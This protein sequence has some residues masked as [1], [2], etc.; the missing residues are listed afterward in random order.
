MRKF[1]L[2]IAATLM[3][4]ASA[5]SQTANSVI[6]PGKGNIDVEQLNKKIDL[7]MDISRLSVSELRVLRN[8]F[9]AR[10]GYCFMNADLRGIFSATSWYDDIM[11]KRFD[12]EGTE[13]AMKP[14]TYTPAEQAFI[15][16]LKAREDELLKL[17]FKAS[18]ANVV[19]M[20]NIVNPFQMSE[21][22][23][24]LRTMLGRQGFAIVPSEEQQLFHIYE[25]NDYH[26][27]PNFVTTDL[28]LQVYHMYFDTALKQVERSLFIPML[29]EYT[30]NLY[31]AMTQRVQ[32]AKIPAMKEAAEWDAA[33]FAIAYSLLTDKPLPPVADRLQKMVQDEI[34]N[35]NGASLNVSVFLEREAPLFDYSIY[36]PRGH[37]T[38]GDDLKRYFKSMMWLQNVP[39]GT[40]IPHFLR[41]ALLI[42][43][44]V[45]SNA[46]F[47]QT[48]NSLSELI[49]FL[50]GQPDDISIL[51]VDNIV[52][53]NGVPLDKLMK[54]DKEL[55]KVQYMVEDLA[56]KQTRI[57]P[58]HQLSSP[59]KIN[60]MPQ[61]YMPDGEVL[62][63]M[64]DYENEPTKRDAP[65]GL[66]VFAA[67]GVGAAEHV[68]IGE[69]HEQNRWDQYSTNLERMKQRM[70]E[71]NWKETVSNQWMQT[72]NG[73]FTQPANAP[74]FMQSP[75]WQKKNL[76]AALASWAE[77]KHDAILYAKQPMGAE[78]GAGGPPE[79]ITRGYV[80]PNVNYWQKAIDLLDATTSLFKKYGLNDERLLGFSEQ[81]REEAE[82]LLS[83]SKKE[84]EGKKLTEEEYS[85]IEYIGATFENITLGLISE[86]DQYLMGW[87]DV[88]GAD[89]SIAV[90]AD[91]YTA[92]ALN[93]ENKSILYEAVGPAHEIY[94]VVEIEGYL[95]LTRGAV[96][97]Y[98][99]FQEDIMMPRLTDEE[100]QEQLKEQP[101]KGIPNWM[102]EIIVPIGRKKLDNEHVFYSSGC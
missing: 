97:S 65:K 23:P 17:N 54:K 68:L 74:Y 40:D 15:A 81:M 26:E 96:F 61:R 69:M 91:V 76:N 84:L 99:E 33:Y 47:T 38:R 42:A 92:N 55:A 8:A 21:F 10:Q 75:Q 12:Y 9:A 98:R 5:W 24:K 37:Y 51:Q 36:R 100:W 80:E 79:P 66:D 35:V 45:G 32:E 43:D 28:Y 63:E 20:D 71:I 88:E 1:I 7:S 87:D 22:D 94:V 48:Y 14:I 29:E 58:K 16:K 72:L 90:V 95:Y 46:Q 86:P 70:N 102:K 67:M 59:F 31:T 93:N 83:V 11:N 3:L 60:F 78:C 27:F 56:R 6:I 18:P 49:T 62:L 85:Q 4:S 30:Y 41:R 25:R 77:L 50:L 57:K 52:K 34:V 2:T 101:D 44:V 19:N 64:V 39:F 53:Q 82:F 73:L 13:K 89:K